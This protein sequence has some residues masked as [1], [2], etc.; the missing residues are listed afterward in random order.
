MKAIQENKT[1]LVFECEETRYD[2]TE[3]FE[4]GEQYSGFE[5]DGHK[6]VTDAEGTSWRMDNLKVYLEP[7][8][9]TST[10][11]AEFTWVIAL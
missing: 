1:P 3:F 8:D 5:A 10:L 11:V 4:P 7:G 6:Y 2:F 9:I